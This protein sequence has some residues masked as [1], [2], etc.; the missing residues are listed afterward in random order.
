MTN[1]SER[2]QDPRYAAHFDVR[3]KKAADAAK[4]FAVYSAVNFSA[5]GLCVRSANAYGVG[6][7]LALTIS[8]EGVVFDLEGVVSWV[9]GGALGVRFVNLDPL[10][11]EQLENVARLL[12]ARGP[13]LT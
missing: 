3:F 12:A 5:G 13:A 6:E 4:A 9:R 1:G 8:I 10:V 7:A 11:R 2:R